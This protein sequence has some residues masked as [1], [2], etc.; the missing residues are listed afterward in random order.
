MVKDMT[1]LA[2]IRVRGKTKV[3]DTINHSMDLLC[4]NRVNHCVYT[5]I[6]LQLE[7]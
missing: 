6:L 7:V 1:L 3:K 4:L 5:K 2:I